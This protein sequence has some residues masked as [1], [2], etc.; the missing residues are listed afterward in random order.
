[1]RPSPRTLGRATIRDITLVCLADAIVALSFGAISV[2][3][4][5]PAW[6]PVAMSVL[7]FAGG[8][9]FAAVSVLL[10]GGGPAAAIAA[11][12]VLNSRLIPYSFAV[13]DVTGGRWWRRLAA[14]HLTT[15]ESV[16]FALREREGHWRRRSAFWICGLALFGSWNLAT[17]LGALAGTMIGNTGAIGLDAAFPAVLLALVLPSLSERG[18]RNA[19]L[20]G[21]AIAV[22]A[23][24][25]LPPGVPMLLAL[26]GLA[27]AWRSPAA[28]A[29]PDL[30]CADSG[31]P[32][33]AP[34]A[35]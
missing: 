18:T 1:M 21:A 22:A 9:Q 15:D 11:G 24:P 34:Q 17:G 25:F 12:L 20:A 2:A 27:L 35:L 16:A 33:P 4:G 10:A 14:A 30:A 23:T 6:A 3:G 32:D 28:P 31:H 26:A 7:V 13:A 5:L 19:A 29:Q 8:S